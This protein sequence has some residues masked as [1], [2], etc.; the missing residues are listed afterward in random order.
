M[1]L[2]IKFLFDEV[3]RGLGHGKNILLDTI[4]RVFF[5]KTVTCSYTCTVENKYCSEKDNYL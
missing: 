1:L 4:Y 3:D 5:K 2:Y